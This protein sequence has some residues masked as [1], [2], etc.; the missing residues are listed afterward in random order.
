MTAGGIAPRWKILA[1]YGMPGV[2][3]THFAKKVFDLLV[4]Q[5]ALA[6][7]DAR[8]AFFTQ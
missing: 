3:K 5:A 1:L 8:F 2:G 7:Y 6:A 4:P